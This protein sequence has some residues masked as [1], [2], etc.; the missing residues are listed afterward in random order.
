MNICLFYIFYR[1]SVE[2]SKEGK[3]SA[4]LAMIVVDFSLCFRDKRVQR[5]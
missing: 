5:R 4:L 3:A 2:E 1:Q